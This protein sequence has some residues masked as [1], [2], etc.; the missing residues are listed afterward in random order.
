[1]IKKFMKKLLLIG[2]MIIAFISCE[3]ESHDHN[4]DHNDELCCEM[5][6]DSI[7]TCTHPIII[8]IVEE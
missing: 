5:C 7:C 6:T 1:M 3:K 2:F 4:H 8:D